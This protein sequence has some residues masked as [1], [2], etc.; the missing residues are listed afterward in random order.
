MGAS[1]AGRAR[2]GRGVLLRKSR[3]LLLAALLSMPAWAVLPS[4]SPVAQAQEEVPANMLRNG[5]FE[6]GGSTDGS[7]NRP[8]SW[9]SQTSP[10]AVTGVTTDHASDASHNG[11]RSAYIARATGEWGEAFW[12]QEVDAVP[13]V[14]LPWGGWATGSLGTDASVVLRLRTFDAYRRELGTV[15]TVA[16]TGQFPWQEMRGTFTA[17]ENVTRV[18]FECVLRGDGDA[19]FDDAYLGLPT[20][21][22]NAPYIVSV[23]P[24]EA[25][26]D[27][28]YVYRPRVV[29]LEAGGGAPL[30]LRLDSAP[31]GM[32]IE[33]GAVRW[34]P[35]SVPEGAVRVVLNAT[36]AVG[37]SGYQDFFVQVL[38]EP[39][40]RPV[41]VQLVSAGDD[42]FNVDLSVERFA[43]LLPSV[44][45][46][47]ED[48]PGMGVSV[49]V[50]LN[51]AEANALTVAGSGAQD[52]IAAIKAAVDEGWAE[53]GYSSL[54][55]PTHR[56]A[57]L[58]TINWPNAAWEDVVEA[59]ID[60]LSA[61]IN[62]TTGQHAGMEGPGGLAA[63]ELRVGDV[64]LVVHRP[65]DAA[66][67]HAIDRY[68][69][70]ATLLRTELR[71]VDSSLPSGLEGSQVIASM[72]AEDPDA[73]YAVYWDGGHLRVATND[74][75]EDGLQTTPLAREGAVSVEEGLGALASHRSYVVPLLVMDSGIYLNTSRQ[76]D[77]RRYFSPYAWA[78]AHPSSAALPPELVR[79]PSERSAAMAATNET[80]GWLAS[81]YLPQR[82]GALV[83]ASSLRSL[84]D[85][86]AGR[87]VSSAELASA[88]F[89][90]LERRSTLDYPS[91]AGVEWGFC[92]GD[93]R[94]YSLAELYGLL[95]RALA[96]FDEG[97]ELPAAVA[98]MA[99]LGPTEDRPWAFPYQSVPVLDIVAEAAHQAIALDDAAWR[100]T[101]RNVVPSSSAPGATDA[102]AMEFLLLM[103]EAFL[104]LL[105]GGSARSHVNLMPT[106]QWPLT[107]AAMGDSKEV[108][109]PSASWQ[110][111]PATA[112]GA[113]DSTP[114]GV[115]RVEP[116]PG[117]RGVRLD[118]NVTVTFS[119]RMD[120][121][122]PLGGALVLEPRA[123]GEL[124]WVAHRLVLDVAAPLAGNTTYVARL[125]TTLAD[126]AGNLLA[127]PFAWSFTT[128]GTA[129][130]DPVLRPSPNS[131][132]VT[133]L[134]DQTLR[135]SVEVEDDGPPPLSY[136]WVLD[137]VTVPGESG[138]SIVH[139]PSYVDEG[140][141]RMTVVV[142]DAADPPGTATHTWT[143][144][145]VNVN[146]PP[147]LVSADPPEGA[148]EV[149]E[150]EDGS[151]L[152]RVVAEDPDEGVLVYTWLVDGASAPP[153]ALSEGG[154]VLTFAWGFESA[155][156]HTV[157]LG[158]QDRMGQ[159][160]ALA[161]TVR[162]RDV[163]RAPVVL[164]T[165][166]P[167]AVTVEAGARV[168]LAVNAT[169]PDGD[170]LAYS[171][172]VAG[173]EAA[174][175]TS[176]RWELATSSAGSLSVDVEVTDGRNG[177]ASASFLV[178]VVPPE[179]R[180]E[181]D[182]PP[183]WPWMLVL[184]A[185]VALTAFI[186]W[187]E[188]RRRRLGS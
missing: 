19:W 164:S 98:P 124:R 127:A 45:E 3:A 31:P 40:E 141:H 74:V 56:N 153:S 2:D 152:L 88:A 38:E 54:Q 59:T 36:D 168:A 151:L 187:G 21:M 95:L 122:V 115:R 70:N 50:L 26:V 75:G 35:A 140:L 133:V 108:W 22:D 128:V 174:S 178:N 68:A 14:A 125:A 72:L 4:V 44:R 86:G 148:V 34:T 139:V 18:R 73:P 37:H 13:G 62:I 102:N 94:W 84:L 53:V 1:M 33:G 161:W 85:D 55:E 166:P 16:A 99:L 131:T 41:Y 143:V 12:Y 58:D 177:T 49:A 134:E 169:D 89:D 97:G 42:P 57:T 150:R 60:L 51:G 182:G 155:G 113:L 119:E 167:W 158:V 170:N 172:L 93:V 129:N 183:A 109:F 130:L 135:L 63:V 48:H 154:T 100:A 114:P 117:A 52:L 106:E 87:P 107:L 157:G 20:D 6:R 184:G 24:L 138:P 185:V 76:L 147:V 77:G 163:N 83:S 188:R 110:V 142:Q 23:P 186:V 165:D 79:A 43:S 171:W 8:N 29:D 30:D 181:P 145:V 64:G 103:A 111:R 39:R 137:G 132:F 149:D 11:S 126:V 9:R 180:P 90:L 27:E 81:V 67:T 66:S 159:G 47:W 120:E 144:D 17:A 28:Q 101:P 160:L 116:A 46:L 65:G 71:T 175:T 69:A 80:L 78:Y 61:P 176:G 162:V 112:S 104:V 5:D 10:P 32:V 91:W 82:G 173:T 146:L 7:S 136:R 96:A 118:A 179:D 105:D 92:R 121:A 123:D 156:E 25:A 15:E